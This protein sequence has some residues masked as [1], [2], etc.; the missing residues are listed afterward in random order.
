[1]QLERLG[2]P[3]PAVFL[4]GIL[5]LTEQTHTLGLDGGQPKSS[6]QV[7]HYHSRLPLL[8]LTATCPL[9]STTDDAAHI[10]SQGILAVHVTANETMG[11]KQ[12]NRVRKK[13]KTYLIMLLFNCGS[14]LC[15][16]QT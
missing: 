3:L 6:P 4:L 7:A 15:G 14:L 8:F 2:L 5:D 9:K 10:G 13:I 1:M 12:K 11:I 16:F